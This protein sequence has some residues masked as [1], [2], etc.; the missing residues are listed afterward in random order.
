MNTASLLRGEHISAFCR[1]GQGCWG[2]ITELVD[3]EL[4]PLEQEERGAQLST[5]PELHP[6]PGFVARAPQCP[7]KGVTA[8]P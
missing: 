4:V 8:W 1:A 7:S 3:T 2:Y 5:L 6:Q